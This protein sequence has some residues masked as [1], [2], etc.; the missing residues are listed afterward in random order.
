MMIL[1]DRLRLLRSDVCFLPHPL[2]ESCFPN[3]FLALSFSVLHYFS[4]DASCVL[5]QG[6]SS[7]ADLGVALSPRGGD[8]RV[9]S[10]AWWAHPQCSSGTWGVTGSA[11]SW[12]R[13]K[14]TH[15]RVST[16][17]VLAALLCESRGGELQP[18]SG[19]TVAPGPAT[20]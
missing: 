6:D 3:V 16:P 12:A 19:R 18:H 2:E 8:S 13:V 9:P 5:V 14:F 7:S 15:P 17:V 20:E 11:T 1:P 4:S 10:G